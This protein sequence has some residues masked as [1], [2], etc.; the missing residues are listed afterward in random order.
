MCVSSMPQLP[1]YSRVRLPRVIFAEWSMATCASGE[2]ST[3]VA[4]Y[5][6]RRVLVRVSRLVS[7][8]LSA[9]LPLITIRS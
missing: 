5:T 3:A 6:L 9:A 2:A 4:T 1:D 7:R 8:P